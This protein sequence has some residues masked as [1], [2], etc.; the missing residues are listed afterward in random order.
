MEDIMPW[1]LLR[2]NESLEGAG[3]SRGWSFGGGWGENGS[4]VAKIS[5]LCQVCGGRQGS[6]T[7]KNPKSEDVTPYFRG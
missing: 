2:F 1:P 4:A 6:Y 5:S 3:T 7:R